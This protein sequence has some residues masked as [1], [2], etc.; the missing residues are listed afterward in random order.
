MKAAA[1]AALLWGGTSPSP[2]P[3]PPSALR[4]TRA[5]HIQGPARVWSPGLASENDHLFSAAKDLVGIANDHKCLLRK[6][7]PNIQMVASGRFC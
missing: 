3:P 4:R 6:M 1:L 5:S 2:P 7:V